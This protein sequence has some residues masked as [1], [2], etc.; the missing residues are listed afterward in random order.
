MKTDKFTSLIQAITGR[1]FQINTSDSELQ[2]ETEYQIFRVLPI[3][4]RQICFYWKTPKAQDKFVRSFITCFTTKY[5]EPNPRAYDYSARTYGEKARWENKTPTEQEFAYY[6]HSSNMFSK[7][8]LLQQVRANFEKSDMHKELC[9][10]GFYATEYGIGIFCFFHTNE[11]VK[12]INEMHKYLKSK[13]IPYANEFSDAR[14]VFRFKLKIDKQSHES[15][16]LAF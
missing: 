3:S 4:K 1:D 5:K 15:I 8:A 16:L 9:K 10:Y 14:W 6:H 13:S 7:D 12:A 11:V 2:L